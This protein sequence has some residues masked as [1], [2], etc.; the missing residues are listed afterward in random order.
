MPL[1]LFIT[2][3]VAGATADAAPPIPQSLASE[4]KRHGQS[5]VPFKELEAQLTLEPTPPRFP[6]H[7]ATLTRHVE[8]GF[9]GDVLVGAS[10]SW[11]LKVTSGDLDSPGFAPGFPDLSDHYFL[12]CEGALK[13]SLATFRPGASLSSSANTFTLPCTHHFY[14]Q[15]SRSRA[16]ARRITGVYGFR[17]ADASLVVVNGLSRRDRQF[18]VTFDV[19]VSSDLEALHLKGR[20][21]G[22]LSESLRVFGCGDGSS[23]T[24]HIE[25]DVCV[26]RRSPAAG[27]TVA[28]P[29]PP[30][31]P[32]GPAPIGSPY[33]KT[34]FRYFKTC[35]DNVCSER[36]YRG[37]FPETPRCTGQREGQGCTKA[38]ETC[39]LVNNCNIFLVCAEV[40]PSTR[41][42]R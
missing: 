41:C 9:S 14:P 20:V 2:L 1:P 5:P 34:Y 17:V 42:P 10:E 31:L 18:E 27:A 30:P 39:D 22:Q 24:K 28:K 36:G 38:G 15:H 29:I 6:A 26:R 35:G 21:A 4:C 40:D 19:S 23:R 3:L 16:E 33:P 37:P 13:T 12:V 7:S 25:P 8:C 11:Y 32:P